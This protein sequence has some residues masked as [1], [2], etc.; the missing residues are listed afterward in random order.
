MNA[1]AALLSRQDLTWQ[2]APVAPKRPGGKPKPAP[3]T[4]TS[5]A[6]DPPA[7]AVPAAQDLEEHPTV[8][9]GKAWWALAGAQFVVAIGVASAYADL[10]GDIRAQRERLESVVNW[11][12]D[13]KTFPGAKG[14]N[15]PDNDPQVQVPQPAPPGS[16]APALAPASVTTAFAS[17]S[18]P[19][20]PG[21]GLRTFPSSIPPTSPPECVSSKVF[22]KMPC[23]QAAANTCRG[24]PSFAPDR[25]RQ[26]RL[27]AGVGEY[28]LVCDEK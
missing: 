6:G 15:V 18:P 24:L 4:A 7:V 22:K 25:Y 2:C 16:A 21:P 28:M 23:E 20:A 26:I 27:Q 11:L 9:I 14:M 1:P 8:K 12:K 5:S 10:K 3:K 17:A 13:P 19:S